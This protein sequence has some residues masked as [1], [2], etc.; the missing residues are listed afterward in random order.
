[1]HVI[2]QESFFLVTIPSIL[3]YSIYF[4]QTAILSSN[5]NLFA[6]SIFNWTE[7]LEM[8]LYSIVNRLQSNLDSMRQKVQLMKCGALC[9]Y[10]NFV[11]G[12]A[13]RNNCRYSGKIKSMPVASTIS[14]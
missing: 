13:S 11:A 12:N 14:L 4:I 6:K 10:K 8:L 1:M 5:V 3:Y 7:H 9:A 2:R